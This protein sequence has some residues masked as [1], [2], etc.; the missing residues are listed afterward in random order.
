[1]IWQRLSNKNKSAAV[2][3]SKKNFLDL[4][5]AQIKDL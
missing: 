5:K 2:L 1:M 4:N 3:K